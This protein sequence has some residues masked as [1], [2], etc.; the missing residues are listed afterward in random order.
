MMAIN[1]EWQGRFEKY[2]NRWMPKMFPANF[3]RSMI[4]Y[5]VPSPYNPEHRYPS[6]RYPWITTVAYVS[7]VLDETAQGDY[8]ALLAQTHLT[9][10]LAIL[11]VMLESRSV[12]EYSVKEGADGAVSAVLIRQ[13][14]I[15]V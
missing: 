12:Y 5:W 7:E 6:V 4:N 15:I 1:R 14:P 2:A 13:R 11:K 8:L 3:Y 9:A 10:D